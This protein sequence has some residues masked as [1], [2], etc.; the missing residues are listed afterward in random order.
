MRIVGPL[1]PATTGALLVL[2]ALEGE[3]QRPRE[4]ARGLVQSAIDALPL[5][6]L[7][8]VA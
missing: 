7:P 1:I 4:M 8:S 6:R 3:E 2:G 5:D